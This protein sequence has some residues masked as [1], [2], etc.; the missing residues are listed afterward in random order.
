METFT[1]L[2][3]PPYYLYFHLILVKKLEEFALR[4]ILVRLLSSSQ[5]IAKNPQTNRQG[6]ASVSSDNNITE[7]LILISRILILKCIYL[8]SSCTMAQKTH[9]SEEDV[10]PY[11]ARGYPGD[12][13][14][15]K[16]GRTY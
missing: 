8:L 6:K 9:Q 1:F 7:V 4:A 13:P 3:I 15:A 5:E 11:N 16:C 14:A 10:L 12:N 2:Y